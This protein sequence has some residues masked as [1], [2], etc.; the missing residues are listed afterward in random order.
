MIPRKMICFECSSYHEK[1]AGT[2]Y[3]SEWDTI[4]DF[5]D[6][7]LEEIEMIAVRDKLKSRKAGSSYDQEV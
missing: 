5:D 6:I 1:T 7:C 3:C 4:V 2:G